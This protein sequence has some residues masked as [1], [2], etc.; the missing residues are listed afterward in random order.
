MNK[1]IAV[2]LVL[3]LAGCA[4]SNNLP[5]LSNKLP[6]L[7]NKLPSFKHCSEVHYNRIGGEVVIDAKC[8]AEYD[9]DVE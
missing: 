3:L 5:S 8:S 4:L 1:L 6:S 2:L 9:D 7:S